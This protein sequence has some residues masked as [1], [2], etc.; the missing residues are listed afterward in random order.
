MYDQSLCCCQ[1]RLNFL[2]SAFSF[3][4]KTQFKNWDEMTSYF[5]LKITCFES[6]PKYCLQISQTWF[7]L[8]SYKNNNIDT[9]LTQN[10]LEVK[11]LILVWILLTLMQVDD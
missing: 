11:F 1:E 6:A 3:N 2:L 4:F 10:V 7:L 9:R 5:F 8:F